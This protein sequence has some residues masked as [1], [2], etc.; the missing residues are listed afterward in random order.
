MLNISEPTAVQKTNIALWQLGFRPFFLS[1]A[2]FSVISMILWMGIY[3]FEWPM[4]LLNINPAIWHAHE[5]LFGYALAVIA[6][7]LLTAVKNWTGQQTITG[8]KLAA[9]FSIWLAARLLPL[10]NIGSIEIIALL[11]CA[12]ILL[13]AIAVAVPVIRVR[14][15]TQIGVIAILFLM[16]TAN[17]FYYAGLLGLVAH[18]DRI[19]IYSCLYLVLMMIFVMGRRVIPFF[20]ERGVEQRVH[21][22]NRK[23]LDISSL[24]LLVMLWLVDVIY[25]QGEIAGALAGALFVLHALR[26]FD[27]HTKGL[28]KSSMLWVLYTAYS[29]LT[30]GFALKAASVWFGISP[31]LS[32]HAFTIG[33]IGTLTLGMMSRVTLGHTG[34]NVLQ[35]PRGLSIAFMLLLAGTIS[36]VF[37]PLL[38]PGQYNLWIGLAQL[39]WIAGFGLFV[40]FFMPML[41]RPRID[42]QPG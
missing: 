31:F 10:L 15:K 2:I 30:L 26:L 17:L 18:G 27:W 36:R 29:F 34:R 7:F 5:M 9:L 40:I 14:Q 22:T 12:F 4:P 16:L 23:W 28:W 35:P 39:A 37:M 41:I 6:G 32:V 21:L 33:G 19:G 38:L 42:G 11:D 3:Q 20:I 13:T 8:A 1:A 24:V 25:Q